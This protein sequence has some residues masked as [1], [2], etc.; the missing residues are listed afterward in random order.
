VPLGFLFAGMYLVL[1]RPA[2]CSLAIGGAI[3]VLG[4][5]LRAMASGHVRKNAELTTSGPYACTRNPLYLGSLIIGT[6]FA[7]AAQSLWVV[8]AIVVLF[9]AIYLPVIR[10]EEQYLRSQFPEFDEY[11]SRVP[12]LGIRLG[13]IKGAGG[14]FSPTLYLEHR[15]YNALIGAALMLTALVLKLL[16]SR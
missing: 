8:L 6:G 3:A 5:A 12:R 4:L 16:W 15:E 7:V 1:A 2:W 11:A 13:N 14:G 10:A 9:L